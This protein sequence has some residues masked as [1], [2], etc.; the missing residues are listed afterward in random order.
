[1]SRIACYNKNLLTFFRPAK[2]S[3]SGIFSNINIIFKCYY[4]HHLVGCD[5]LWSNEGMCT[6][7][8]M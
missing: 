2:N 5:F 1:M 3:V 8:T 6:P 7:V 4:Y